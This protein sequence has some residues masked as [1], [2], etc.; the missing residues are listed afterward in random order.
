MRLL[1]K[2]VSIHENVLFPGVAVEVTVQNNVSFLFELSNE[3][4]DGKILRMKRL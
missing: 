4:L 1:L 2:V 3:P